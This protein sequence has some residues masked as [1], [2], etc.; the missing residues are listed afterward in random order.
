MTLRYYDVLENL[1][2]N[3]ERWRTNEL[4]TKDDVLDDV[5]E[6]LLL[7]MKHVI[8]TPI[9]GTAYAYP[10]DISEALDAWLAEEGHV[11]SSSSSSAMILSRD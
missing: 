2:R 4:V 9:I 6:C 10:G 11:P 7:L 1:Y 3:T 5:R 8:T